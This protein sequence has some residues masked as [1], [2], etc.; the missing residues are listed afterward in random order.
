MVQ[1]GT[2]THNSNDLQTLQRG[3]R[4]L[5]ILN[6]RGPVNLAPLARELDIPR[7]NMHR[8]LQTLLNEG[9]IE[10]IPNSRFYKLT[11]LVRSLSSG[12][13]DDDLL[14]SLAMKPVELLCKQIFWP[15]TMATPYQARMMVRIATDLQSPLALTRFTPGYLAPMLQTTTG[16][17]YLA[18]APA[19]V[20]RDTLD[21]IESVGESNFFK[22]ERS[23]DSVLRTCRRTGYLVNTTFREA[24]MGVPLIWR[25]RVLGGLATRY[26]QTALK[27]SEAVEKILPKLQ[28]CADEIIAAFDAAT[29]RTQ[30]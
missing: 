25:D 12:F 23:L 26:I 15:V 10:R 21:L 5:R 14:T 27:R 3:L 18:F 16:L 2:D 30:M 6:E 28:K 11:A 29:I 7:S 17:L 8:L 1:S 24:S 13:S 20:R 9:Y 4:L 19:A 22:S